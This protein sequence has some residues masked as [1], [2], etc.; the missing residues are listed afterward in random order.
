MTNGYDTIKFQIKFE[1]FTDEPEMNMLAIE[2]VINGKLVCEWEDLSIDVINLLN[3]KDNSGNFY[4]WTC[5]CGSPWCGGI[6]EPIK[7]EHKDNSVIWSNLEG[8]LS[9]FKVL[10]FMKK[11]Y[12][13]TI[14]SFWKSYRQFYLSSKAYEAKFEICPDLQNAEII[15]R[16]YNN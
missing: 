10:Q 14:D 4:I 8:P 16:I 6:Y 9:D 7:V 1:P 3:S 11:E 2:G 15:D 13:K 5:V 12:V